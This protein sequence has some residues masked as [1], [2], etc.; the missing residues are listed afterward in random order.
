M[1][2][3]KWAWNVLCDQSFIN[4]LNQLIPGYFFIVCLLNCKWMK[5]WMRK[6]L[7]IKSHDTALWFFCSLGRYVDMLFIGMPLFCFI[8]QICLLIWEQ[9]GTCHVYISLS[10]F[11]SYFRRH[12]TQ[13]SWRLKSRTAWLFCQYFAWA[14]QQCK[15]ENITLHAFCVE[16]TSVTS[17]RWNLH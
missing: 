9:S 3:K 2:P 8:F 13:A 16:N 12:D 17:L 6:L 11:I 15:H 1:Y 5:M 7:I 10:F 14:K 4:L